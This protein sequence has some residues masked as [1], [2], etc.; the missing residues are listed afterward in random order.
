MAPTVIAPMRSGN[1]NT[2]HTPARA[3]P[4]MNSGQRSTAMSSGSVRSP[5]STGAPE[6]IESMHGPSPRVT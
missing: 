6:C 5:T 3:A 1:A 2:A 4:R